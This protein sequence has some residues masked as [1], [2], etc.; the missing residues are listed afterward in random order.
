VS[1]FFESLAVFGAFE[2]YWLSFA[3]VC[4][5][6]AEC[7]LCFES[8][9][10]LWQL[11]GRRFASFSVMLFSVFCSQGAILSAVSWCSWYSGLF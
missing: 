4:W 2:D 7:A 1:V 9:S 6:D 3:G 10:A 5:A 11:C 8:L